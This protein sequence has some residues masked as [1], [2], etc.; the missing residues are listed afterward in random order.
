[1]LNYIEKN[2]PEPQLIPPSD[3]RA[4]FGRI[5]SQFHEANGQFAQVC[6]DMINTFIELEEKNITS[7]K[8]LPKDM[9][10]YKTLVS[11]W[12]QKL[13]SEMIIWEN[14]LT[15]DSLFFSGTDRPCIVDVSLF[16][17]YYQIVRYG[18]SESSLPKLKKWRERMED[19]DSVK[20]TSPGTSWVVHPFL[21]KF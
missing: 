20:R 5:I 9:K 15:N 14:R 12:K 17:Y 8:K 2:Y 13:E 4:N 18:L 7:H 6:K 3:D 16:P 19:R 1:M 10:D 21:L 11:Y